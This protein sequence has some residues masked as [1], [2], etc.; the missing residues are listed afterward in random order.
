MS[1]IAASPL[2]ALVGVLMGTIGAG[3]SL[4]AIPVLIYLVG[5]DVRAAQATA[6]VIVIAAAIAG[7]VTHAR[8]DEVRWRAGATFGLAAGVSAL[9][10]SILSRGID[11]DLLLL[12]FAPVM[13]AG[14]YA[15]VSDRGRR[16]ASFQPWRLGVNP[17][18]VAKVILLGL[19]VG[20][21]VGLFG[22]GGGFVIVPVLVLALHLGMAEAVGTSL[23]IIAVSAAFALGDR[24]E[25]GDID[26]AIAVP[27]SVAAMLGAALGQR[28]GD[29]ISG[30]GLRRSFAAVLAITA[31]GIAVSSAIALY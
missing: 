20:L 8:H 30:E 11:D 22:V 13:I 2:G 4:I 15:M 3:G 28:L 31:A 7:I 17:A 16:P 9:I 26:W 18:R 29:R 24:I 23:L 1:G 27:F 25:A 6:L 12:L 14:A 21:V 5:Q 10:G 19:A